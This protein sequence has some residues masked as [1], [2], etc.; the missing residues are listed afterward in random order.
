MSG[1]SGTEDVV[2]VSVDAVF[3][4]EVVAVVIELEVTAGPALEAA[5]GATAFTEAD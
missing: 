2:T 5:A 4:L 3:E 1:C